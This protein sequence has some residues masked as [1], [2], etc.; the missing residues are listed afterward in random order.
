MTA[1]DT[2][3]QAE[4][5][6]ADLLSPAGLNDPYPLYARLREL[7]DV[8]RTPAGLCLVTRYDHCSVLLHHPAMAKDPAAG[9][10]LRGFPDWTDHQALR[11]MFLSMLFR[12]PP[13]HT[14]L[15]RLVSRA[16]TARR[17]ADLEPAPCARSPAAWWTTWR[18][19]RPAARRSS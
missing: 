1:G 4:D 7:G 6:V 12:N 3:G 14:R 18:P 8:Q 19:G 11:A 9:L 2:A 17:V 16:F 10:R 13:D 5:V 15:R